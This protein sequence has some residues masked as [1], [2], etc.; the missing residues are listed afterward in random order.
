MMMSPGF[1]PGPQ[2]PTRLASTTS[3]R[4]TVPAWPGMPVSLV[5][6]SVRTLV[7]K[8][9][10]TTLL[11]TPKYSDRG[12]VIDFYD[13]AMARLRA[14][15]GVESVSLTSTV[16]ISGNDEIYSIAFEGRPP[17]PPGQGVSALYYLVGPGYFQT[18]G[19]PVL[20]G[21][22]FN[23]E[24]RDGTPRVAIVNDVF[25]RLHYP[26]ENP[27]GQRIRMGRNSNIV[28]EIVGVAGTVKHYG[29]TD[30]DQAQMYEPFAQMPNNGMTFVLKTAV[31]PL[32]LT[33]AVRQEIQG[34][35]PEQPVAATAS[36]S[37]RGGSESASGEGN[38]WKNGSTFR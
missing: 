1:W 36:P 2:S 20:K 13:R 18:M 7:W 11:P 21:R 35:D 5:V 17:M 26:N 4:S 28:R 15:P 22:P 32:S 14:L 30:K 27:I 3:L 12:R 37:A 29:L 24:D 25:V 9:P 33:A 8:S 31:E 23:E 10:V 16:P 19:I 38:A 6:P 34:V